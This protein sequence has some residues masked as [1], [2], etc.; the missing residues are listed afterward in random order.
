MECYDV[1]VIGGGIVGAATAMALVEQAPGTRVVILEKEAHLAA[2]QTG[3]NSGVIHSGLYYR[4]GSLKA[5]NCTEGREALYAFCAAEG[6]AHERCGKVVVATDESQIE[7]LDELERRG[8]ENG[9]EGVKRLGAVELREYEPHVSGIAGLHVPQT[10]IVD[11]VAVT[12]AFASRVESAGGRILTGAE[13]LKVERK[14]ND[15]S[16]ETRAGQVKAR[17]IVNC[18]G[19]YSDRVASMCGVDPEVKIVPFRGEYYNLR[20][21]QRHLVRNLIYPVP[22][23]KFPFLGVHFTRMIDGTVEAGP[24]A[25]LAF[26]REGYKLWDVS[27]S[28][29]WDTLRFPGFARLARRYWRVGL[30][31]YRRSLSKTQMLRD[32]RTLLPGL[33]SDDVYRA[34]AGVRAQAVARDG[35]LLDDFCIREGEGMVHVLNAPSP[36]ATASI[37]IGTT[38]AKTALE[39][40]SI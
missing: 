11:F 40:F 10:G 29:L 14:H 22:D 2:H 1:A 23:P 20:A 5:R 39:H 21:A 9:L 3:N 30:Q 28:D 32:L 4:P 35:S 36:A 17:F 19:L 27:I 24:N 12:K 8:C 18:A 38:V 6:I 7:A 13:V 33:H 25:V 34:G 15:F 37:S 26:K 31:E 16:L